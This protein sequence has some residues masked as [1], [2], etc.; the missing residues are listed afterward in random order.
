MELERKIKFCYIFSIIVLISNIFT[1]AIDY[2]QGFEGVWLVLDAIYIVCAVVC[3]IGFG[4]FH[5]KKK[6]FALKYR[7]VFG[8]LVIFACFGS[9]ILA[10]FAIMAWIELK[11][12]DLIRKSREKSYNDEGIEVEGKT[13]P[14]AEEITAKIQNL[15]SKKE[16]GE[17]SEEEYT[18]LKQEILNE[19]INRN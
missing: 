1:I 6:D 7:K 18:R 2:M 17:I 19:I 14:T 9:L 8:W 10:F 15:N 16:N 5:I 13:V 12:Y 4:I 11:R 3:V